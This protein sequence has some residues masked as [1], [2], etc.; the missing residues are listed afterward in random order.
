MKPARL[1]VLGASLI[2]AACGGDDFVG[3]DTGSTE[4]LK[5]D[6]GNAAVAVRVSYQA[7]L[8]AGDLAGIGGGLG[9]SGSAP[10]GSAIAIQAADPGGLFLDVVS[11]VPVGPDVTF[12]N[13]VDDTSGTITVTGDIQTPGTLTPGDTF[14]IDYDMCDEGLGEII[15]GL[16]ELTIGDFSGDLLNG[17]Y[18]VAMDAVLTN[19]QVTTATDS[20]T[21]NGDLSVTL[22][23]TRA[24]LVT[25]GTSG[26]R[27]TMDAN[28]SS[29][30][31]TNYSSSQTI[32]GNQSPADYALGAA[33]TLNSTR[34]TGTVTY[35]TGPDF[36]GS[37]LDYPDAGRLTVN[38]DGSSARLVVLDNTNVRIEIDTDG[39][40]TV[41][42][43]VDM[44]WDVLV[45]SS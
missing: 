37:G 14:S 24:P 11:T 41:D 12:C 26:T 45:N 33:G 44:T 15:D 10:D 22:D 6:S 1:N 23:T 42:E 19:L 29:E 7:A 38:G 25:A 2:I 20:V 16:V 36:S 34:L 4:T 32:D 43:S 17:L 40:G 27:L 8:D 31:L 3:V 9:L 28:A 21:G 18:Q 13:G 39:D 30:T 5:I 35:A